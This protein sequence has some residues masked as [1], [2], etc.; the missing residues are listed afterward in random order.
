MFVLAIEFS[1]SANRMALFPVGLNSNKGGWGKHGFFR[2]LAYASISRKRYEIRP[3]LL[4]ITNRK[5]AY[6]L[7]IGTKLG[8]WPWMTLNGY[9][10][11]FSP[12]N[13]KRIRQSPGGGTS[14]TIA[15]VPCRTSNAFAGW[16]R[17]SRVTL[18]SDRLS[19]YISLIVSV[20]ENITSLHFT[21]S[22]GVL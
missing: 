7:S 17:T 19:C 11:K 13:F 1:G 8:R 12:S 6:A 4:L 14:S 9:K 15:N 20:A 2:V 22:C 21:I 3:M 18:A 10:F 16:R 5:A